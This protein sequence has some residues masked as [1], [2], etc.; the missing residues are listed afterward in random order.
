MRTIS[1]NCLAWME[2]RS[3]QEFGRDYSTSRSCLNSSRNIPSLRMPRTCQMQPGAEDG[4]FR[5]KLIRLADT[6]VQIGF[7][8]REYH[9]PIVKCPI[10]LITGELTRIPRPGLERCR[11]SGAGVHSR[12]AAASLEIPGSGIGK[13]KLWGSSLGLLLD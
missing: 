7:D 1:H 2:A 11:F 6:D 3:L 12:S 4:S 10:N 9:L 13:E 8:N 5:S